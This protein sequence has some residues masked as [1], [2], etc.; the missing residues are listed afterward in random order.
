MFGKGGL[1]G[2]MKQAQQMQEKMQKMQ[3]EIAQLE[4][5][6]ESGAGL[7]K[8]TINGAHNCRRIEI[9]PSLMDD[10]VNAYLAE[11]MQ[12]HLAKL[13]APMGVYAT[14]GNHDLF[15]DQDRIDQEIR[16][17]GITVL[18]DETLTLNNELVLIGRN[19][20]LAH[21][22]PSTETLL[23]QVNTD[24]PII[25]LDHRPTD[26]EKHASLPL[27]IQ[28]SGH[29]HKGQVFPA[30]LITKMMYRLD[31]GHEKIGNPHVFVTL[32]YGFWGIPMRLGSQ[33]EVVIIDIKEK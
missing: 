20:N 18:R 22:R 23:K 30:S 12:P 33:S 13:K 6:G 32:G 11:K 9:D 7:V 19:D 4:V 17:A 25:L 5:T 26:I 24:L 16:K 29:A 15:G 21:D 31:Y 8:I 14:L 10:N 3:E 28:V 27:D 1:G 2:L